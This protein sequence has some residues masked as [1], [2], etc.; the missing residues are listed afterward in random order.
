MI[1]CFWERKTLLMYLTK[2][3]KRRT[4]MEPMLRRAYRTKMV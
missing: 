2:F 1:W 3:M 4:L